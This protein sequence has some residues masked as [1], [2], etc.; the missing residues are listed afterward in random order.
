VSHLVVR[1]QTL[2]S[3][4]SIFLNEPQTP[5]GMDIPLL[6][7]SS[8]FIKFPFISHQNIVIDWEE[9]DEN[10]MSVKTCNPHLDSCLLN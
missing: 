8:R 3:F 7:L 5:G 1:V 2:Q 10:L 4:I 6:W 9:M